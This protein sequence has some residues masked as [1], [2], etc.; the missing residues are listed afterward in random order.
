MKI[1]GMGVHIVRARLADG[2]TAEYHYAWRGG[3]RIKAK[4]GTAA[5]RHELV[6]VMKGKP[7]TI[8][9]QT[10]GW[11]LDAYLK[12]DDHRALATSTRRDYERIIGAIRLRY[13]DLD[14]GALSEVGMRT[15]FLDWRATMAESPRSAD[16]HIAV[17]ARTLAWAKD[18]EIV[19]A[20]PLERVKKLWKGTRRDSIWMPDDLRKLASAK[21]HIM[22]AAKLALWT[23]QRQGDVLSMPTLRYDATGARIRIRQSKTGAWLWVPCPDEI[24]PICDDAVAKN[25]ATILANSRGDRW[26]SDGFRSSWAAEMER[27]KIVGPTFH[28]LRGTGISY[29]YAFGVGIKRIAEISGHS[30]QECEAI[31][32]KHY[33]A[34][35]DVIA[36]IREGTNR[37]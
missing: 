9:Q 6:R 5:Y 37:A 28:D 14:L 29:A 18:R 7:S 15:E 4:P 2:S 19:P 12:S 10:L 33:L 27:L 31:I 32:R 23:M 8:K 34:G 20:N 35:E 24:K 36:A 11:L 30:E 25:R 22:D 13:D 26:T 1:R 3:P 21:P 16:L 17:L